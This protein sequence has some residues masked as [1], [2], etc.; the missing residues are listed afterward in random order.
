MSV[1]VKQAELMKLAADT[2]KDLQLQNLKLED[3]L[4][5]ISTAIEITFNMLQ[6]G[7]LAAEDIETYFKE[8]SIKSIDD[9]NLIK[10]AAAFKDSSLNTFQVS[11]KNEVDEEKPDL[12][13]FLINDQ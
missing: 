11:S 1:S 6:R 5:K 4:T 10:E 9:L 8:A 13:S 12:I 3:G 2:I 7:M